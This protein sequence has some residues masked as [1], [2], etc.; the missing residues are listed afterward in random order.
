MFAYHLILTAAWL[1]LTGDLTVSNT[2]VG[3][4]LGYAALWL[5]SR[6]TGSKSRSAAY[7]RRFVTILKFIGYFIKSI[8]AA[9]LSMAKAVLS[10]NDKL[11]PAIVEIPLTVKNPAA[12][13]FLANWITLTPGTLTLEVAADSSRLFV[14][15][16]QGGD[17]IDSFRDEIKRDFE[18]R[19][20]E[21]FEP[22]V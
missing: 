22:H 14:H 16:F 1:A 12:V 17:D 9:N 7:V 4:V 11:T 10:S 15:T 8:L 5:A 2:V 18:K 19:V 20:I 6:A 3:F 13:T 21:V